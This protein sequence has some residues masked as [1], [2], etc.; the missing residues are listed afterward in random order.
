M[1]D[2]NLAKLAS[3]GVPQAGTSDVSGQ[4]SVAVS[5]QPQTNV[6]PLVS[7]SSMRGLVQTQQ[8]AIPIQAILPVEF[9]GWLYKW[10]NYI[11]GY[12]K[13]WF[14]LENGY[15]RYYRNQA[16]VAYTC[17]GT[18]NLATAT[19]QHDDSLSIIL[20]NGATS[21][22]HLKAATE[23][24]RQQWLGKLQAAHA[25][26]S[27]SR[28]GSLN[29]DAVRSF[30]SLRNRYVDEDEDDEEEDGLD[31]KERDEAQ[32]LEFEKQLSSLSSK[33]DDLHTCYNLICKH[34]GELVR[35]LNDQTQPLASKLPSETVSRE[36]E[37]SEKLALF[38]ITA[39][40]MLNASQEYYDTATQQGRKW[41]RLL[42]REHEQRLQFEGVVEQMARQHRQLERQVKSA[43]A[44]SPTPPDDGTSTS[45]PVATG[46]G[47]LTSKNGAAVSAPAAAPKQLA[48]L[49]I[50][51]HAQQ[52]PKVARG[53]GE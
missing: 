37:L 24:E 51:A 48:P 16:E 31:A 30:V 12:Q 42:E 29:T 8:N 6:Q 40:T 13:R 23:T 52:A 10:T 19:I 21:V 49:K 9:K 25:H 26:A 15:L 3:T 2:A 4:L 41:Q 32:G 46:K 34:H 53:S 43:R 27:Q 44:I 28:S 14:I 1:S 36:K 5:N 7:G 45:V 20:Q 18:M 38:K 33:M 50:T 17:R 22:F 47:A 11:K 35:I 39:Q